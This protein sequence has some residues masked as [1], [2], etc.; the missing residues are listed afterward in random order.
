MVLPAILRSLTALALLCIATSARA[1]PSADQVLSEIGMSAGDRQRVVNGEF[2]SAKVAGVSERDLAFATA[3]LVK[4]SPDEL[5]KQILAGTLVTT[6]PQV[7]AFGSLGSP[8]SLADFAGLKL[9]ADEAKQ[10]ADAGSGDRMNLSAGEQDAFKIEKGGAPEA[11]EDRLRRLL[12]SRYEAYR[13][14]GLAG[15]APYDR[16]GAKT[17]VASDLR[18]A[19]EAATELNAR[20]PGFEAVLLDYPRATFPGMEQRFAWVKSNVRGKATFVL[21]H[22]LISPAGEARAFV[23]REFYVS[24]G[25]D[26]E[27]SVAGFLPVTGG[28]V[29]LY[30]SHAFTDQVAGAG[31]SVKRSMGSRIM[32][33]KM[34]E[35][36]ENGRKRIER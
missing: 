24:T 18:K 6:D 9:T 16:G 23:R 12:L 19:S 29:V 13:A 11:I 21:A 4:A 33:D 27:Q 8:P 2:V 34:K 25:Y 22:I 10:L 28:A 5:G 15:I 17:D 31:G 7:Q 36:F 26:A 20:L 3:F 1:Q 14:S 35:I 30:M 32:A